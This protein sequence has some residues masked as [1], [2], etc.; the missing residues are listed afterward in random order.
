V[1]KKNNFWQIS[2]FLLIIGTVG[3]IAAVLT[4]IQA[5]KQISIS[6]DLEGLVRSHENSGKLTMWIFIAYTMLRLVLHKFRLFD[7]TWKW[8]YYFIGIIALIILFRTGLLGGEMVYIQ[9]IGTEK[10][11]KPRLRK[12]SFND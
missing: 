9:G 7:T 6:P 5:Q 1:T 10:S 2:N 3:A 4:G 8:L 12:P 11:I